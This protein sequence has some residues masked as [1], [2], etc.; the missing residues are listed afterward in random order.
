M[1]DAYIDHALRK[2]EPLIVAQRL[3]DKAQSFYNVQKMKRRLIV[4]KTQLQKL[5][6]FKALTSATLFQQQLNTFK[7][8]SQSTQ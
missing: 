6:G 2:N 4:L 1:I 8:R 7:W 5:R 3:L